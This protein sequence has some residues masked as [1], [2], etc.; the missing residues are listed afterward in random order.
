MF[1]FFPLELVLV[2][3]HLTSDLLSSFLDL[4]QPLF[5]AV[6]LSRYHL[7]VN[8]ADLLPGENTVWTFYTLSLMT[9]LFQCLWPI[10]VSG[11]VS[12][13]S[14]SLVM[15]IK[16]IALAFEKSNIFRDLL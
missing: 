7:K 11:V 4:F 3:T 13:S 1:S 16:I 12:C 9:I 5:S 8:E 2:T 10:S 6:S 14:F 15:L